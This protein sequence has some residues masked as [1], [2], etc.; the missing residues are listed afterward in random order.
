MKV[1]KKELKGSQVELLVELTEEE[2]AP[3]VKKG[4]EK[5]SH[6]IKIDGFRSGKIPFDVLKRKIGEMAIWEEAAHIAV[7]K[8]LDEVIREYVKKQIIDKPQVDVTK[9]APGNS[10]EYKAILSVL[11]DVELGAYKNLN[12]EEEKVVVESFE[13]DNF[14]NQLLESRAVEVLTE[15][16]AQKNDKV[17]VDIEMFLKKVP[18]EGGQSR[19]VAV[20]LGKDYIV[21]GF[22]K[23]LEGVKKGDK[24]EFS[25]PYP[26]DHYMKNLAGQKVD[27]VVVIKD[28]FSRELPVADD[29]FA[30]NFGLK[31]IEE[32]RGEIEGTI[33]RHKQNE[34]HIKTERNIF[35]QISGKTKFGDIPEALINREAREMIAEIEGEVTKNGGKFADYLTSISKTENELTLEILPEAI[36]RVKVSLLIRE[37]SKAEKIEVS[38]EEILKNLEEAK[39]H[40]KGNKEALARVNSLEYVNYIA[41]NLTVKK[42]VSSLLDWNI[43]KDDKKKVEDK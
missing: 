7:D 38:K 35:D 5:I 16:A 39:K 34:A 43:K 30:Q 15:E 27:F 12:I 29:L 6:E 21:P 19:G 18:V 33:K 26:S 8:T 14:I 40:Y 22:D 25:L 24:K 32:L 13:V 1:E 2:F 20:V 9:L 4:A 31:K 28:V 17:I 23:Q 37:I 11:P 41:S 36:K 42:V 3:Y 10:M